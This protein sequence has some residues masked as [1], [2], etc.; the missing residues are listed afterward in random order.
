MIKIPAGTYKIGT[1]D[2]IGFSEDKEGPQIE[3][4]IHEFE[5]SS[6]TVTNRQFDEFVKE[7]KYI[8]DAEKFGWSFVFHLLLS[9][10]EKEKQIKHQGLQWWYGVE[11][12]SWK[13]PFGADSSIDELMDHPV[14]HVSRNDAL[15]YCAWTGL[16]LPSEAEWEVAAKG[17][18]DNTKFYWEIDDLVPN[19]KYVCNTFQGDFPREN[20][21]LDGY[22]GTAPVKTYEPNQYGLYQMIGNVWEWC[23]NPRG[24]P[25][26]YFKNNTGRDIF[27]EHNRFNDEHYA[28]KGGSFLCHDSYCNRYRISARTGNTG[29]SSSSNLGFRCVK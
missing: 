18:T 26:D 5:I 12:C 20:D 11:G 2:G 10:K 16:R 24:V 15:A 3:V 21:C 17:K 14:V 28:I 6:T 19:G 29:A 7:T 13:H 1:N 27:K 25:L 9:E 22:L 23:S 4:Y 8:T